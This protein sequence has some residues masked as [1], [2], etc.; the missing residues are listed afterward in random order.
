MKKGEMF[1]LPLISKTDF[2][3]KNCIIIFE[4]V[5]ASLRLLLFVCLF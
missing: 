5:E 3:M 4:A 2:S 1:Y